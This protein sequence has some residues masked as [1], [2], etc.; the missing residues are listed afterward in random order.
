AC[1]LTIG[2]PD[3]DY[4]R[5]NLYTLPHGP[6]DG[7]NGDRAD[8]VRHG[9]LEKL[10][11]EKKMAQMV[12]MPPPPL[13]GTGVMQKEVTELDVPEEY[14]VVIYNPPFTKSEKQAEKYGDA[15]KNAMRNKLQAIKSA[16]ESRDPDAAQAIATGSI[17][18]FFTPL[19]IGLLSRKGKMAEIV[20]ATAC[21]SENGKAERQYIAGNLHVEMVVTS[22]DPKHM[23]FSENTNIHECLVIGK[24]G[25]GN[26]KPTRFIQLAKYP[27]DVKTAEKLITAIE[28][29][30]ADGR[31][32]ET[33]WPADKVR[34]GDWSPVQW[35]NSELAN[36]AQEIKEFPKL[37]N[38]GNYRWSSTTQTLPAIFDREEVWRGPKKET[39]NVFCTIDQN[40]VQTINALPTHKATPKAGEE[41]RAE[42]SWQDADYALVVVK[43][44]TTSTRVTAVYSETPALGNIFRPIGVMDQ[45]IAKAYVAFMNSSFG[46]LQL[47][48][49]RS[50]KLTFPTY[51][52]SQMRTLML[53][54]PATADLAPLLD[55]FEQ[56]KN[57]PLQRLSQCAQD[58]ARQTLDHAAAQTLGLA[59]ALTDQWRKWLSHEPTITNKPAVF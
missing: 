20:P 34:A 52:P 26:D 39:G 29:G 47:L 35:M 45:E 22:H 23:N 14:E 8:G 18:P 28:S 3:T 58:P 42:K 55:A 49:L 50:R 11:D 38:A 10:L 6:V 43:L 32:T 48:N 36:V 16:L 17:R 30:D 41:R 33:L 19:A 9:V 4:E 13:Y 27:G 53:P 59:P 44:S 12:M 46:I 15:V 57:T 40:A 37:T 31:Y 56:V 54:D 21:T 1:N 25:A 24:R 7:K 5:M 51:T 2:A